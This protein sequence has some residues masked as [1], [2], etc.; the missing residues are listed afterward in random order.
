MRFVT[1][2]VDSRAKVGLQEGDWV[3]DLA[4]A[5]PGI[6]TDM[7]SFVG[8]GP[9]ALDRAA[10]VLERWTRGQLPAAVARPLA[11]ARLRAPILEPSK[12]VAVGL[13]YMDHCRETR[14]D[15]PDQPILFA[16]YPSSIIGPGDT[17][18]WD[19]ALT[20]QVDYEAELAIVIG[21]RARRVPGAK[22]FDVVFGYTCGNDV[23][24][25]DLQREDGQWV[26]GKSLDTF[27]PLGPALV[28]K[29]EVQHPANLDISCRVNGKTL[30]R[31]NTREMVF[32]IPTLIE[33]VTRAFTL[34]PGDVILTG[35]PHG[36][37]FTRQPPVFLK[38]GDIVEVEV[39]GI[40]VLQNP[41]RERLPSGADESTPSSVDS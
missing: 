19:P 9:V 30:Q 41:C 8:A 20:T 27:C 34:L 28:T 23:T 39:E 15:P 7:G 22:A 38:G 11:G 16:K 12:I 4:R 31:S 2:D 14:M 40:G 6:P 36:V 21:C 37:G 29:D 24:A 35:T 17:V 10:V 13:N 25:R 32:G 26:R 3:I 18:E 33:F 5:D 1:F